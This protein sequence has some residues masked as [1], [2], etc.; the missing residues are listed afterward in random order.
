MGCAACRGTVVQSRTLVQTDVR[1]QVNG[2][3]PVEPWLVQSTVHQ[4]PTERSVKS[5]SSP[6]PCAN[7]APLSREHPLRQDALLHHG[8]LTDVQDEWRLLDRA[9]SGLARQ[10]GAYS[11]NSSHWAWIA[12]GRRLLLLAV[13]Q[14]RVESLRAL[15]GLPRL[16]G[17]DVAD[18][19]T[20][21]FIVVL[22]RSLLSSALT[23]AECSCRADTV[24]RRASC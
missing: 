14:R 6:L 3:A 22:R 24:G 18:K 21:S 8:L 17:S 1:V 19:L 7:G 13:R 15:A 5:P 23:R 20:L 11:G 9:A 2:A 10:C 12:H 16:W 4:V